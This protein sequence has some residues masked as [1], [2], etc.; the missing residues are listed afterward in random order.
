MTLTETKTL[1]EM[2][3]QSV[4]EIVRVAM[5]NVTEACADGLKK[6]RQK[7]DKQLD[8]IRKRL[9]ALENRV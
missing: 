9:D 1:I 4:K 8:E 3:M 5:E 7:T 6:S 2:I